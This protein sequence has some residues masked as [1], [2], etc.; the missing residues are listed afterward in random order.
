[1][2]TPISISICSTYESN[3]IT[4]FLPAVEIASIPRLS[5]VREPF[6][7]TSNTFVVNV[8]L[9][10]DTRTGMKIPKLL[11]KCVSDIKHVS[12]TDEFSSHCR[13]HNTQILTQ[14]ELN[15]Y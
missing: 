12:K 9:H 8:E 1:M 2:G 13:A 10:K 5:D 3:G 4:E 7:M 11:A 14:F 15:Q 6:N